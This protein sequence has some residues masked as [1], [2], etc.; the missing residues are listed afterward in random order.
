MVDTG[1]ETIYFSAGNNITGASVK[2]RILALIIGLIIGAYLG[3][4]LSSQTIYIYEQ[5]PYIYK[6][7]AG[8]ESD[9]NVSHASV[10]V[11]A[12][13]QDGKGVATILDVQVVNGYGRTLTNIDRLL[14]WTDTQNSIRTARSVAEEITGANLSEYDIIYTIKANATVIEGASAGAALTVATVAALENKEINTSVMMT[15]IIN[16][17]GTIGP[18]GEILAKARAAKSVGAELLIV[19]LTQSS[20][21]TY[22]SKK[23]CEQIGWSQICTI[24]QIPKKVDISEEAGIGVVEVR[25]VEE[26]LEYFL[27]K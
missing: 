25:T 9:S 18:V 22:E 23:Y 14:F 3:G 13:T 4:F 7:Y 1:P 26:A 12:V 21:V 24:E 20:Q 17:D 16:H 19:P 2:T 15:G 27:I 6:P 11:P 10:M 8:L 5:Y